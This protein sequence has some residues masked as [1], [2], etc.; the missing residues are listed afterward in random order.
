[1][2]LLKVKRVI[3]AILG[4]LPIKDGGGTFTPSGYARETMMGEVAENSGYTESPKAAV[5]TLNLNSTIDPEDFRD[6][7]NDTLTIYLD[8]GGE[9]VMP[10]AWITEQPELSGSEVSVTWNSAKSERLA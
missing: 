3:S 5:L 10:R 8:G 7:D 4:E 6:I 2:K 1:M 9:H